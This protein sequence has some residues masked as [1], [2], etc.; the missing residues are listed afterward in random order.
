[1]LL[2]QKDSAIDKGS[3]LKENQ[4]ERISSKLSAGVTD[5]P[6]SKIYLQ[7]PKPK[8]PP[9]PARMRRINEKPPQSAD[10]LSKPRK[11]PR[12]LDFLGPAP[13]TADVFSR[14]VPDMRAG[15]PSLGNLNNIFTD[16]RE[17]RTIQQNPGFAPSSLHPFAMGDPDED[18]LNSSAPGHPQRGGAAWGNR[19]GS[20]SSLNQRRGGTPSWSVNTGSRS[21]QDRLDEISTGRSIGQ[22]NIPSNRPTSAARS[23]V[24]RQVRSEMYDTQYIVCM[25]YFEVMTYHVL[26]CES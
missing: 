13:R 25:Q 6:A 4:N 10:P 5:I 24:P 15:Q 3:T 14:H 7:K 9:K 16:E 17:L 8:I 20:A 2:F 12:S 1:M 18:Q 23:I 11:S 22:S 21:R 19:S 26:F